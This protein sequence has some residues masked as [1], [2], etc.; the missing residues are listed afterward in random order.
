MQTVMMELHKSLYA[1]LTSHQP[2]M[3]VI[4]AVKDDVE[5]GQPFPY[6][7]ISEPLAMPWDTKNTIGE[8]VTITLH[9]WSIYQGKAETYTVMNLIHEAFSQ[10]LSI[11]GGFFVFRFQ[12]DQ[13]Q[14]ITDI[15]G[16][17]RHG[18]M[19]FRVHVNQ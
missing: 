9:V 19:R 1:G 2:L 17:T 16:E 5:E 18:I 6:V 10:P 8:E 7:T 11:E 14:V 12:R 4:S 3:D 15:D 13:Q